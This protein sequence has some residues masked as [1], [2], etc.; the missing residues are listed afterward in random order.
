MSRP[1]TCGDDDRGASEIADAPV[2]ESAAT[3]TAKKS[4]AFIVSA[5]PIVNGEKKVVEFKER[6]GERRWLVPGRKSIRKESWYKD[7]V[8]RSYS[9]QETRWQAK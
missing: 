3:V 6:G 1:M 7:A 8:K 4:S 2:A 9:E 5:Q